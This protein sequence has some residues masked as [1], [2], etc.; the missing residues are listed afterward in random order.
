VTERHRRRFIVALLAVL[1]AGGCRVD[2]GKF[3]DRVFRCDTAAPDPLCGTDR[4]GDAMTCFAARQLGGADF[5]VEKCDAPM[6]LPDE[7][8]MCVQGHAKLKACNPR[9]D[10]ATACGRP[11]LGCLR[12]DIATDEGVCITMQPCTEDTDCRDPVRSTCAATFLRDMYAGGASL[13]TDHLYCLQKD[14]LKDNATCSPGETCLRKVVPLSANPPDICVPNCNSN[15][16]CPPNHLCYRKL[17]GPDNPAVCIPGLLGFVCETDVDCMVGHCVDDGAAALVG[18]P[19]AVGLHLC[20]LDC[21]KDDDCTPYDSDQGMFVCNKAGHCAT[22]NAYRGASCNDDSGCSRNPG[23][24]CT[25]FSAADKAAGQQGTCVYPC[26]TD[27]SECPA[28]GGINHTCFVAPDQIP[29]TP[30]CFP[31]FFGFPCF[32]NDNCVGDLSCRGAD[33][34]SGQ[35]GICTTLCGGPDDCAQ[36]RWTAGQSYCGLPDAP[37]C[38]PLLADGDDC[39]RAEQ[40]QTGFCTMKETKMTCGAGTPTR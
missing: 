14:C 37:V 16:E 39:T 3:Q 28:L 10:P 5:C 8:A 30:V 13:H 22:P 27:G 25:W 23:T 32:S 4:Q 34:A 29:A 9:E 24:V 17:S 33:P 11:E 6:S 2:D 31:G 35:P 38:L 15:L 40:C 18:T 1:A 12:T 20:T 7:D 19:D 21:N 26:P 36:D